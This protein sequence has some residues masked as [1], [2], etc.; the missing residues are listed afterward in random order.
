MRDHKQK[1]HMQSA[2]VVKHM[3][4]ILNESSK[5]QMEIIMLDVR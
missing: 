2:L 1:E 3:K 4:F 5:D